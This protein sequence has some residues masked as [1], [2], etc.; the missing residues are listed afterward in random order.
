M[1]RL[2]LLIIVLLTCAQQPVPQTPPVAAAP[3]SPVEISVITIPIETT[4]APLVPRLEKTIIKRSEVL[5][6]Y[7]MDARN[8]Y[9]VRYRIVREP[10]ALQMIGSG[11][12]A[13]AVVRYGL[14][15]CRRTVNPLTGKSTLWPCAS[16]GLAGKPR[17]VRLAL[18]SRM[19]WDANWHLR[20]QTQSRPA[21]FL[22]RCRVTMFGIDVTDRVLAPLVDRNLADAAR[23]LDAMTPR[24]TNF[25]VVAEQ[26]W[27]ALHEPSPLP[28]SAWLV[29]EPIDASLGAMTGQGHQ[30]RTTLTL[31]AKTTIVVGA[32]PV[33]S[34]RPLPRLQAAPAG[35][36]GGVR[37]PF[38]VTMPF[39]AA[40]RL[41]S[42]GIA[43]ETIKLR[44]GTIKIEGLALVPGANGRVSILA[45][46]D[47]R[48]GLLQRYRGPVRL[49]GVPRFEGN[50]LRF[51]S[52]EYELDRDRRNAFIRLAERFAHDT[53]RRRIEENAVWP[54]DAQ[55]LAIRQNI[56]AN[57]ARTLTPGV[58]LHGAITSLEPKHIQATA[59][60]IVIRGV[61]LGSA[62]IQV[63]NW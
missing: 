55:L 5:D 24:Q 1:R 26:I 15:A 33:I 34:L 59:T 62:N 12:H 27:R 8:R 58:T 57:L 17:E 38:E 47:Y 18:H 23:D 43:G 31:R 21:E 4:L 35:G 49:H 46:I 41:L 51:D 22:D 14:E 6:R 53:L 52:L 30:L 9:G 39:D 37:V 7:E 48:A 11:L 20:S 50:R 25:R 16:C 3:P 61:A 60:S 19:T 36:S 56:T 42:Q 29:L 2:L 32:K 40:S 63:A 28:S 44:D 45:T 54:L 10:I 13:S